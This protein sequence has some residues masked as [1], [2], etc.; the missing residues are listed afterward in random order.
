MFREKSIQPTILSLIVAMACN[1]VIGRNNRLPWHLPADLKFFK[2]TTMGK[3]LLMGRRTHESIGRPLPGRIN[4]VIT[5]RR[6]YTA[7]GCIVAHSFEEALVAAGNVQEVVVLGGAACYARALPHA[8]RVYLTKVQAEVEGDAWF[9]ELE[10]SQW[11]EV[12][13]E[14]HPSDAKHAYPYRFSQ[15][16]R[17]R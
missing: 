16:E 11:E 7:E 3:T 9:P 13:R 8:D 12:W 1:R 10:S 2:R 6:N 14:D 4:I 17:I 15:L 5:R